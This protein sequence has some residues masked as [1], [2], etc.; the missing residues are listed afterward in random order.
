MAGCLVVF[1]QA[2]R[3]ERGCVCGAAA[4]PLLATAAACC[5]RACRF[6]IKHGVDMAKLLDASEFICRAIGKDNGSKV[7]KALLGKRAAAAA[8]EG[9]Q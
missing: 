5:C 1:V 9:K 7:A 2:W 4:T 6:G 3:P 8:K